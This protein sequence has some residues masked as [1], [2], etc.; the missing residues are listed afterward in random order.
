MSLRVVEVRQGDVAG[1]EPG[2]PRA[3]RVCRHCG[4]GTP[5]G[6]E[7]CCAGCGYVF[8]L[9]NEEGLAAYYEIKDAVTVPADAVTAAGRDYGWLQARQGAVE[10]EARAAG[11][12]TARMTVALQGLSCAGCVWLID[13]LF[14]KR[15]GAGRI[16]INA[17][18]GLARLSWRVGEF[19][20]AEWAGQLQRFNYLVGPPGAA[21]QEQA[22]SKFLARRV[23]LASAL[24]LNI[25]LFT[26][27][28][29]FG[30]E[31]DFAY[32]RLF[33]TL[34]LALATLSVLAG[35]GYFVGRAIR[36]LRVGAVHI[37]LPIALGI[38]GAYAGSVYG[39]V[40]GVEAMQ[41]F[42]FVGMFIV[43]MLVGRWAQ[44][45]AVE[46]NQRRLLRE[47]PAPPQVTLVAADGS[48]RLVG[49]E[50]LRAGDRFVVGTGQHV[51]VGARMGTAEGWLSL[52]WINGEAAP[53]V[54]RA[55]Q[56]VPAGAENVT[57]GALQ[58]EATQAWGES[59]LA[60]LLQ[61]TERGDAGHGA[62]DRVVQ[63]YVVAIIGVAIGAALWWGLTT[64][65]VAITGA[66]VTA[67][68]VVSCPCAIGLA[69]PLAD[70]I[71]TVALR[72]RGVFV[73]RED[74][75]ARLAKLR[76]VVFDKTG[77]LTLETPVVTNPDVV[78]ALDGE[79]RAVL[80]AMVRD[81]AHPVS[82][83]LHEALLASGAVEAAEGAVEETI[84][85]G[86][87]LG[88]WRLGR[89]EWATEKCHPLSDTRLLDVGGESLSE[90]GSEGESAAGG[91]V[92]LARAGV[93]RGVF[94]L[95]DEARAGAAGELAALKRRG[96]GVAVLSGDAPG[97]VAR[98]GAALGLGAEDVRGGLS[99]REKAAWLDAHGAEETL[100]LGDGAN[101]S[102]AFDRALVRGTP[103]IHRGV[104]EAKADFYYL[105][106]GI[107][108]VRALLEV[109]DTRRRAVR[110]LLVFSV[111]YNLTTVSFAAG[112]LMSPLVAAVLM[113][114][115]S[116]LSLA[117]VGVGL[118]GVWRR[119]E[120]AS[121]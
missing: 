53:R 80:A 88:A 95:R 92:V 30:M 97:K 35:G 87:S 43:L 104:L 42:D 8:R 105:G 91:A 47:Q 50:T 49:P 75:W 57:R 41:Y 116:L 5:A 98:L 39:W 63:G 60:E 112:G 24:A 85:A 46:R 67:V 101:D 18:T 44:V 118:R 70:E 19:D 54:F 33:E 66:V 58:L 14:A 15:P 7:F 65:D 93:V 26:L 113:P 68:L 120:A 114:S 21:S 22:E 40:R 31:A 10:T 27:P 94:W 83:A 29:Y 9:I 6:E 38:V 2:A 25:M 117:I 12:D 56:A 121:G 82:R 71:A 78:A 51:P 86:V 32:A 110:V 55:G 107:D 62:V 74:L 4:A 64:G 1:A 103:V 3:A 119:R 48:E 115:S 99:P 108:G 13:R 52:A 69:W 81:N 96:L 20:A 111:G 79:A 61:P 89:A 109:A 16:E 17:Q 45:A 36:A 84:G 11:H 76:R 37:D 100:M 106:R 72:R 77:T 90:N 59:H 102:L 28:A 73:R 23:G 34:A